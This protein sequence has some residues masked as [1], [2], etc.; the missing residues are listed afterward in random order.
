MHRLRLG[1]RNDR[2]SAVTTNSRSD[3]STPRP[4]VRQ[5]VVCRRDFSSDVKEDAERTRSGRIPP[6]A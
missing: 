4:L 6:Q 2:P 1:H 3:G 5:R